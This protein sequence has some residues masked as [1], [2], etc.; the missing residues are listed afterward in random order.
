M[1]P[2]DKNH[3][4]DMKL[5]LSSHFEMRS[6][7]MFLDEKLVIWISKSLRGYSSH[8]SSKGNVPGHLSLHYA[9]IRR[10]ASSPASAE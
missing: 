6:F 4:S 9:P 10:R 1:S 3:T 5:F 8:W 2:Y 7:R